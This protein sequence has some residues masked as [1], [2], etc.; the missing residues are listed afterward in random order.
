MNGKPYAQRELKQVAGFVQQDDLLVG[1][2]SVQ[3]TLEFTAKL[4]LPTSFTD[5]QRRE[6]IEDVLAAMGIAHTRDTL[7]GDAFHKGVSGGAPSPAARRTSCP[8]ARGPACSACSRHTASVFSALIASPPFPRA[9]ERK[10]VCVAQELLNKPLLLFLD[11][12]T[13]GAPPRRPL[14]QRP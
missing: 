4:R 8:A 7:I 14:H 11:E 12:P 1:S 3:E 13:S 5:E 10:R 6:R 9:G 2:M